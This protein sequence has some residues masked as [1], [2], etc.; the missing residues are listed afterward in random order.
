[1]RIYSVEDLGKEIRIERK[2]AGLTQKELARA[3]RVG[4]RFISDL[5]N[6]KP[7]VEFARAL[8]VTNVLSMDLS[9]DRR[10]A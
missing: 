8:L 4:V 2:R 7:T 9:V 5:E 6:G 1:M 10:G 3:C